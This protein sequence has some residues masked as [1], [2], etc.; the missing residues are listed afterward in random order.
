M[1]HACEKYTQL[2]SEQ[3]ER[4][5]SLTERTSMYVHFLM[6]AGCKHYNQNILKLRQVF[7]LKRDETVSDLKLPERKRND[8]QKAIHSHLKQQD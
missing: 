1:K 6:C 2:T 7:E 8:I 4:K 3:L 5:L